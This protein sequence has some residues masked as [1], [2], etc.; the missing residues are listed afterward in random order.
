MGLP[1]TFKGFTF[2]FQK[3]IL[4]FQGIKFSPLKVT[5]KNDLLKAYLVLVIIHEQNLFIKR[6][7][8]IKLKTDLCKTAKINDGNDKEEGGKQLF[9]NFN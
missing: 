6:F 7:V 1:E 2:R 8:N 3:I 9:F 5:N 4:N